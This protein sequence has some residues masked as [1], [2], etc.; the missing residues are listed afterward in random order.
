MPP[1]GGLQIAEYNVVGPASLN[2]L[3]CIQPTANSTSTPG[4]IFGKLPPK[5]E[6]VVLRIEPR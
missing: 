1:C 2:Y 5:T 4:A 3:F 6:P